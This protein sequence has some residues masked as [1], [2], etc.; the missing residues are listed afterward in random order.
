MKNNTLV[1]TNKQTI[2]KTRRRRRR[3][4]RRKKGP[5]LLSSLKISMYTNNIDEMY[6]LKLTLAI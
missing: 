4:R 3:R 6:L 5:S 1:A 2:A